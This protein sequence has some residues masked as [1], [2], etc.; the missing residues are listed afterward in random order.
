MRGRRIELPQAF[1]MRMANATGAARDRPRESDR[2]PRSIL[3]YLI[4]PAPTLFNACTLRPPLSSCFLTTDSD[5][6]S[7]GKNNALLASRMARR[8]LDAG[9]RPSRAPSM[10]RMAKTRASSVPKDRQPYCDRGRPRRQAQGC[11]LSRPGMSAARR[12]NPGGPRT[13][14]LPKL[15]SHGRTRAVT[16]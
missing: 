13:Q 9:P 15:L 4:A 6:L 1:F 8:R 3:V 7:N 12:Q 10:A 16:N 14:N 11:G 5:D 2:V